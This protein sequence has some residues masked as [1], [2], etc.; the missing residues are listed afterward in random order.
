[1]LDGPIRDRVAERRELTRRE[2]IDAAWEV[3]GE[4]GLASLTLRQIAAKVG[5]QA[6]SLYS[7]FESKNAIY[8]EMFAR[9]W[10]DFEESALARWANLS[11]QPR[12][13]VKQMVRHFFDFAVAD[14]ARYQLMNQRILVGFEP[15]ARSFAPS[16]R[17]VERSAEI[18]QAAGVSSEDHLILLA[19]V[20]GVV[21]QHFANDP[22]GTTY[23][24]LLDRSV[25]MWADAVGL[26]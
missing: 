23:S 7:H 4:V 22:G 16:L 13:A 6:P 12:L 11:G 14:L 9:A 10:G 17:V 24:D 8:D 2:I 19:L 18:H 20:S 21:N 15:T 5:M 26:R 3:A 25:D 1:M